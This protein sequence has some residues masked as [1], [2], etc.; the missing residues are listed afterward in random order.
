LGRS[1]EWPEGDTE[2]IRV[3]E[4][5]FDVDAAVQL[6]RRGVALQAGGAAGVWAWY[7]GQFFGRVVTFEPNQ[8]NYQCLVKNA[9]EAEAYCA[10]LGECE[11]QSGIKQ[12]EA[13]NAGTWYLSGSGDIPIKT[14]DGLNLDACDLICLDIEGH[15]L[16]A[17]KGAEQTL[18]RFRPV[19]ML[20][21]KQLPQQR[22]PE[23][24]REYLERLGY[25]VKAR[26]HRDIILC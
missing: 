25:T 1:W 5:V 18:R 19:V 10:G 4:Y 12:G 3:F 17:L 7:L 14:I 8:Q 16:A 26:A 21:E 13:N 24:A 15:E 9:P 23:R 20:E 22:H 11:S 6:S 2:L